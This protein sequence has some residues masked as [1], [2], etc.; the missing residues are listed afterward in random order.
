MLVFLATYAYAI[1]RY[2][3]SAWSWQDM[4]LLVRTPSA[5]LLYEGGWW[6]VVHALRREASL[7]WHGA[8]LAR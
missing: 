8:L 7:R 6:V 5:A 4:V 2:A 3:S 1:V